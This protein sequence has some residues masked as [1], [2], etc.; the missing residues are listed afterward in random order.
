MLIL[1]PTKESGK[2]NNILNITA[3]LRE[4][5]FTN[6]GSENCEL[7]FVLHLKINLQWTLDYFL[8]RL[9]GTN[10]LCV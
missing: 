4:E 2:P 7:L 6:Q 9:S 10:V 5:I 8:S 1:T 3:A